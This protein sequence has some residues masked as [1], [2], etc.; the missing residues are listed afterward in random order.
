[1]TIRTTIGRIN[2]QS[3]LLICRLILVRALLVQW[4][5]IFFFF[6]IIIFKPAILLGRR[7]ACNGVKTPLLVLLSHEK[8]QQ[9]LHGRKRRVNASSLTIFNS[10]FESVWLCT[11]ALKNDDVLMSTR[12]FSTSY[13]GVADFSMPTVRRGGCNQKW[14]MFL[15]WPQN[16]TPN[17]I[18]PWAHFYIIFTHTRI[19]SP[20]SSVGNSE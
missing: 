18:K 4:N 13:V 10:R 8:N 15:F 1:M 5:F 6:I 2:Q 7:G 20:E 14:M 3:E 17:I 19:I 12:D 16:N 9:G 11:I